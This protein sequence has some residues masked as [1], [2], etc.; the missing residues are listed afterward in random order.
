MRGER[1]YEVVSKDDSVIRART[2]T[3]ESGRDATYT[4]EW[5]PL[6]GATAYGP[7]LSYAPAYSA[8]MFPLEVGKT[9]RGETVASDPA[10]GRKIPL[11]IRAKVAGRERIKVPAGE[12]DTFRIERLVYAGDAEWWRSPTRIRETEWYA[13]VVQRAVR[14]RWDSEYYDNTRTDDPLVLGDRIELELISY[15]PATPWR[16]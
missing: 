14:Q 10:S 11:K 2:G 3:A 15:R 9:W 13:A 5:N 1:R 4:A 7:A 16:G 12:F 6:V 8:Y